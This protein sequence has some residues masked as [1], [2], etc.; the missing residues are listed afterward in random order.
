MS[1]LLLGI[2]KDFPRRLVLPVSPLLQWPVKGYRTRSRAVVDTT[3]TIP[4]FIRVQDD[5]RFALL[6][7]GDV[8][9]HL[10]DFHAMVATVADFRVKIY[11][12][13]R[14]DDIG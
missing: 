2:P 12:F 9:I 11:R 6:R 13:T 3:A 10:A 5:R 4:A 7:V 8:N 1:V 14:R